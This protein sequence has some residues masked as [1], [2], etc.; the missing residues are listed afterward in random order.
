MYEDDTQLYPVLNHPKHDAI[1]K[2]DGWLAQRN[3]PI[4]PW[5]IP[6]LPKEFSLF[7]KRDDLTGSTLSGN[8][9]RKLEFLLA[10]ALDKKCDTIFTCGGIQSNHCRSTAVA[11]RQL[12]LNC[13]LF[14]RNLNRQTTDIGCKGNLLLNRMVGSHVIV[15]PQLQYKSGLKQMMEKMSEKL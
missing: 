1:W 6:N 11:A 8:K 15:V 5:N 10:D 2:I 9:I 12:G 13:Y 14:L 3:T 4:H 7:I